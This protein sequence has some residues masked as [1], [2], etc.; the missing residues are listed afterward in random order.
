MPLIKSAGR[1]LGILVIGDSHA[2]GRMGTETGV[3]SPITVAVESAVNSLVRTPR[4]TQSWNGSSFDATFKND[5]AIGTMGTCNELNVQQGADYDYLSSWGPMADIIMR[6]YGDKCSGI[7]LCN[8]AMGGSTSIAWSSQ[9]SRV[10]LQIPTTPA[11]GTLTVLG[12]KTYRWKDTPAQV[13]DV[14]TNAN[15]TTCMQNLA[16]AVNEE[17]SG[18]FA[19]T[20]QNPEFHAPALPTTNAGWF[21][22]VTPGVAGDSLTVTVAGNVSILIPLGG[23]AAASGLWTMAKGLCTAAFGS[24]DIIIVCL[25]T[26]DASRQGWRGARGTETEMKR[27]FTNLAT[28]YP[29]AKVVAWRPPVIP[30]NAYMAGYVMP[31]INAALAAHPEVTI[32]DM[33]VLGA[34]TS[35]TDMLEADGLHLKNY[36]YG[37]VMPELFARGVGRALGWDS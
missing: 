30:T 10:C 21:Y 25:G 36:Q 8:A 7:R 3:A 31:A 11:D 34:G 23:G 35:P 14:Q 2:V 32:V 18:F 26:N 1:N 22:A 37:S 5:N 4:N 20:T 27:L 29:S 13:N 33:N 15:T 6:R 28:D 12:S 24:V 9:Q 16:C 19:G 17:F